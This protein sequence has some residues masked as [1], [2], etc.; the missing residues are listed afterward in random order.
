M[1][2]L[3]IYILR[4]ET[5]ALRYAGKKL[6]FDIDFDR[7]FIPFASQLPS[8][9]CNVCLLQTSMPFSNQFSMGIQ[10]VLAG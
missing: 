2:I 6:D 1:D 8:S 4:L 7:E 5:L 9:A 10:Q 3:G